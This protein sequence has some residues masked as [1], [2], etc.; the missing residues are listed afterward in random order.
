MNTSPGWYP[1]RT[2]P[3]VRMRLVSIGALAA[4]AASLM[5]LPTTAQAG[6]NTPPSG[7]VRCGKVS[8]AGTITGSIWRV[9]AYYTR[10]G[11]ARKLWE[12]CAQ[13]GRLP[14]AWKVGPIPGSQYDDAYRLRRRG[15]L[16]QVRVGHLAGGGAAGLDRCLKRY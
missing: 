15:T 7:P 2:H 13:N 3:V 9:Y 4:V 6:P 12:S 14:S 8:V 1:D 5:V 10:C 16:Q 11:R